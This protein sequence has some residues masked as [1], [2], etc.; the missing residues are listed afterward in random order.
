MS[1]DGF[2]DIPL[3]LLKCLKLVLHSRRLQYRL[4][5][6]SRNII[7]G[8]S[9]D[10]D[11]T[12]LR[13]VLRAYYRASH[14]HDAGAARSIS[15]A[16]GTIRDNSQM[17]ELT[18]L[19]PDGKSESMALAEKCYRVGRGP[20]N[21]LSYPG[22]AGLSREH[23][24]IEQNGPDWIVRDLGSTNG[25]FLNGEKI[26]GSRPLKPTD[27][28]SLG[29]L[30]L[31]FDGASKA[32]PTVV[33]FEDSSAPTTSTTMSASVEKLVR[34]N[35]GQAGAHM[36]ALIRAGRELSGHMPLEKLF[37]LIMNLS[38]EAVGASRGVLMTLEKGELQVRATKGDGFRISSLV[39]DLVIRER[40]SLLVRD[41]LL[42]PA[43]AERMS[44]VQHQVRGMLAAP[45]QTEDRVIGLIYLDAP[46]LTR[47]FADEDLNMLTVMANIAAVRIEQARLTEIE[48]AEKIRAKELEHAALIQRSILPATFPPFPDRRDF[49]LHAAML[50]AKEVGGDFF[51]FFLLD[52]DHLGFVIGDV[53]GKGVPAALF[54]AVSRTLLHATAQQQKSPGECLTYVNTTL[55]EQNV[56]GMFV[57]LFYGVLDTRTGEIQFANAGHNPP[58]LLP[59]GGAP[60]ALRGKSGPMAGCM[61]GMIYRTLACRMERGDSIVLYTDGVTEALDKDDVF[62]DEQRLESFLSE[63]TSESAEQLVAGL[64]AA[65]QEF[66][67]GTPQADDITVLAL[68]YLG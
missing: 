52:A 48:Q 7:A 59:A 31:V 28:V 43:L 67:K 32:P 40:R 15:T 50:P 1:F 49:S 34:E 36:K 23:C 68:K 44:I 6:T 30:T 29:Q 35:A 56:S 62:F 19:T 12:R 14:Y 53:S 39:R 3:R 46:G 9:R 13:D 41:A 8:V 10:R 21:E 38:I 55:T 18:V 17:A 54:M 2:S 66:S 22:V 16:F 60:E 58:Y 47:E 42:D 45:L 20:T 64:H 63:H 37:D 24:A 51:D 11:D 61:E 26:E 65:V 25:T 33:F 27:R 5:G 57:T 4:Q